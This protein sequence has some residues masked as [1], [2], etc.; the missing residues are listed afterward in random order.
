LIGL[1][2]FLGP[3]VGAATGYLAPALQR[4]D[5]TAVSVVLVM[6]LGGLLTLRRS[7]GVR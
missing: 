5:V 6:G 4:L 2:I 1:G 7:N 3:A